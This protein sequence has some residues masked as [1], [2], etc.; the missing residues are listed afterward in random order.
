MAEKKK[1]AAAEGD[2]APVGHHDSYGYPT[3]QQFQ[4]CLPHLL[5]VVTGSDTL[6]L[7]DKAKSLHTAG[8]FALGMA[9]PH[10]G[11]LIMD[12]D[13]PDSPEMRQLNAEAEKRFPGEK[14]THAS[15]SPLKGA[16]S[17]AAIWMLVRS[18]IDG[19]VSS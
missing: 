6:T 12:A 2:S 15:G 11:G 8:S 1:P 4:E 3:A 7:A 19:I 16:W 17:W 14:K 10:D 9:L 18:L 13:V 5:S